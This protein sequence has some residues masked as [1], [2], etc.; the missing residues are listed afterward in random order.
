MFEHISTTYR[1]VQRLENVIFHFVRCMYIYILNLCRQSMDIYTSV[2]P[3]SI[4]FLR[5]IGK[6]LSL[7]SNMSQRVDQYE[8]SSLNKPLICDTNS[9]KQLSVS[10]TSTLSSNP[11]FSCSELPPPKQQQSSTAQAVLNGNIWII[12]LIY[13]SNILVFINKEKPHTKSHVWK[14]KRKYEFPT[15]IVLIRV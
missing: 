9:N 11:K 12:L 4:G 14:N 10:T 15:L 2:S 5:G 8:Y 3:P 13:L 7:A 1:F 6:T